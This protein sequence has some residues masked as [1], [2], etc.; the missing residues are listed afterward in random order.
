MA[1]R[2]RPRTTGTPGWVRLGKMLQERRERELDPRFYNRDA[3][4]AATGVNLRLA[5]EI[6][7]NRRE[8]ITPVT[9]RDVIAP[10]YQVTFESVR[11]VIDEI[12]G[13]GL[14]VLPGTPAHK[15]RAART[16]PRAPGSAP[17]FLSA[18]AEAEA[19]PY[20]DEI[21]LLLHALDP[22]HAPRP[23][24]DG[25]PDPGGA[26]LFGDSP[27]AEDWDR[28]ASRGLP[29]LQRIWLLAALRVNEAAVRGRKATGLGGLVRSS[30]AARCN[31]TDADTSDCRPGI[32][33]GHPVN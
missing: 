15:P 27:D 19:Q 17:G 16:A 4:A 3:F 9:L 25:I 23:G 18:E 12:P 33:V 26:A 2:R 20:A 30:F 10:A 21:W 29:V 8:N 1:D 22:G 24:D 13:A 6:E 32:A 31:D 5:Q 14:V 7:L 11:A 28:Y